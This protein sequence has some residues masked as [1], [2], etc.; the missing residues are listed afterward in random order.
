MGY[1]ARLRLGFHHAEKTVP[2]AYG[3]SSAFPGVTGAQP[4][5]DILF[6]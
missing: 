6:P 4:L 2:L 3:V 1:L 5:V